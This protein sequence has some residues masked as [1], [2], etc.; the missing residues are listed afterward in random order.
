M[1][2]LDVLKP[3][4]YDRFQ[5]KGGD[6]SYNC[7]QCWEISMSREEYRKWRKKKI[8]GRDV[9]DQ[10]IELYSPD[11][12]TDA[13][14]AKFILDKE[15]KCP[16]LTEEGLCQAQKK[17]G[18]S[19][20]S[21]TCQSFPRQN[22]RYLDQVECSMSLG[23]EKVLEL[24]MEEKDGVLL[25]NGKKTFSPESRYGS[26]I[27]Q[28]K[29][30]QRPALGYYYDIQTL[31]IILL[32]LEEI[33]LEDR[34]LLL[35]MAIRRI[36][37]LT[38][39]G[40]SVDIPAYI[41]RFIKELEQGE[42]LGMLQGIK[43]DNTLSVYYS[44]LTGL[45]YLNN[46]DQYYGQVMERVCKRLNLN[47][48]ADLKN[49]SEDKED[50]YKL[51]KELYHNCKEQFQEWIQG[52]EYFLENVMISYMFYANIPFKDTEKSIWE[53]YL[54]FIWVYSMLKVSLST[55]L[56]AEST[57]EDMIHC[58][59]VLFRK[60]GHNKSLFDK[61]INDFNI[62]GNSLAHLAVLLKSC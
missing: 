6:C 37:E 51:E 26:Y 59:S 44:V 61:V 12:K 36:D 48:N 17:Y 18:Y 13:N 3:S 27:N 8:V 40:R 49:A 21:N 7:C 58:C 55:Y 34:M 56:E 57:S 9:W 39:E 31:C 46:G 23:C 30:R 45:M 50:S 53:N 24:L 19:I 14:Y 10:T 4:W 35:G 47:I 11:K 16:M 42:I 2:K 20:L 41:D 28:N 32:Q 1:E 62:H 38:A 33:P 29:K 22:H 43:A 60:L 5:C 15:N 52:K 25:V 54:Y